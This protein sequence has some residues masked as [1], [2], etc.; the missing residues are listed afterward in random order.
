MANKEYT[1]E[2]NRKIAETYAATMLRRSM[3]TVLQVDLKV[4]YG[5]KNGM[6]SQ[7]ID[8]FDNVF[9]EAKRLKN[10]LLSLSD[11]PYEDDFEEVIT[12]EHAASLLQM[13]PFAEEQSE[14]EETEYDVL[15]LFKAKEKDYKTIWYYTKGTN[16]PDTEYL[17]YKLKYLGAYGR[18][19][20]LDSLCSNIKMLHT[21][22]KNREKVGHLKYVSD[23]T[24]IK[25]KLRGTGFDVNIGNSTCRLQGCK[26]WFKVQGI[27]Q[28]S[29]IRK[30][31]M[32]YEIAS[33]TLVKKGKGDY[34]IHLAVY[35]DKQKLID[36]RRTKLELKKY[37]KPGEEV[38]GIDFGCETSFTLSNGEKFNL[39]VEETEHH[40][41]LQRKL[42]RCQRFSNNWYKVKDELKKSYVKMTNLKEELA[43]QFVHCLKLHHNTIVIQD[44][45]LSEWLKCNHGKAVQHSILG[46]VKELLMNDIH[47]KVVVLDRFIPTTKFCPHCGHMHKLIKVW[48]RA[49]VCPHCGQ[50]MD[51]DV[52]AAQNMVWIYKECLKHNIIPADGREIKREDFDRLVSMVF[53]SRNTVNRVEGMPD[54]CNKPEYRCCCLQMS[55]MSS[56]ET[57]EAQLVRVRRTSL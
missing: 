22:K 9:I 49:Y 12:E 34:H 15:N 52:H 17:E 28:L 4:K 27:D 53:N 8:F 51:R 35:A 21:K 40:K 44:E 43:R 25:Y 33:A 10:Y 26:K 29:E 41:Q 11:R 38:I 37:V 3:Q 45:N 16:Q 50:Q 57:H 39:L 55:N 24:S 1:S 32:N 56:V 48:D 18:R 42:E 46:R 54:D 7:Q 6:L 14:D 5:K 13:N 30:A 36:Y 31:D 23:Y 20:V 2:K 19:D 47:I